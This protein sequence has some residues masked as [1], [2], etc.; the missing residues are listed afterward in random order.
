M[1]D[2]VNQ[3]PESLMEGSSILEDDP[4]VAI[5]PL[6][7]LPEKGEIIVSARTG[8]VAFY[9]AAFP[10]G[11]R[12]PIH[13]TIRLAI[14]QAR[15]KKTLLGGYP[16]NVKG[17][18]SKF[19]FVSGDEWE[20]PED[21]H[22]NN[23]PRMYGDE[24]KIFDQIFSSIE[25]QG[26]FSIPVLLD[27]KSFRR[28]FVSPRSM[29]FGTVGKVCPEDGASSS[30]SDAGESRPS[31]DEHIQRD[32]HS[33]DESVEFLGVIWTGLRRLGFNIKILFGFRATPKL[34]SDAMSKRIS[35]KKLG[36]KVEKLK[37][38]GSSGGPTLAK[39]VV[40]GEKRPIDDHPSSPNEKGKAVD[41]PKG[42]ETAPIPEARKKMTRPVDA[43]S[44]ST[45]SNLGERSSPS[46]GS[47]KKFACSRRL[48]SDPPWLLGA[49]RQGNMHPSKKGEQLQWRVKFLTSRGPS[50]GAIGHRRACQDKGAV[51]NVASNYF[52]E[53]FDFCK[54]MLCRHHPGLNITLEDMGLDLDLLAE[55]DEA[56]EGEDREK[57]KGDASPL[58]S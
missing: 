53:G 9:E 15:Y 14:L 38:G 13:P 7:R 39:G 42:K 32:S 28:I 57:N 54:W 45:S 34:E 48:C 37:N 26:C 8:E 33:Q 44:K 40:I 23:P 27:S 29:A 36:E 41:S 30:S 52:G 56:T 19:F 21:K 35:L 20:L 18:K 43:G 46:L 11:L 5:H 47:S 49:G 17:W 12:F 22:Y 2:E 24:H 4:L 10:A 3:S 58:P 1:T 50:S 25:S 6:I 31:R 51:E 55:E 16:S